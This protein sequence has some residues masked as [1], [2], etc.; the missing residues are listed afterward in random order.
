MADDEDQIQQQEFEE[1]QEDLIVKDLLDLEEQEKSF[2]ESLKSEKNG[3]IPKP[4]NKAYQ[5]FFM[6]FKFSDST[7]KPFPTLQKEASTQ[8]KDPNIKA[9]NNSEFFIFKFILNYFLLFYYLFFYF[10][11]FIFFVFFFFKKGL[12]KKTCT[13]NHKMVVARSKISGSKIKSKK[14]KE[15]ITFGRIWRK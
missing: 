13:T 5:L 8:W 6:Y 9:V 3:H 7:S 12:G 14:E 2:F 11:F 4:P 15:T 10:Y 1:V